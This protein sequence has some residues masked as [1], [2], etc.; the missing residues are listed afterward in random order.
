MIR[1]SS[2]SFKWSSFEQYYPFEKDYNGGPLF[3]KEYA[4]GA[5]PNSSIKN[6]DLGLGDPA[7]AKVFK[8][9]CYAKAP[10]SSNLMHLGS[11]NFGSFDVNFQIFQQYARIQTSQSFAGWDESF[12]RLVYRK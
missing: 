6:V 10:A 5:L 11:A 9:D 1:I 4:M 7:S 3:C 2:D 8:W 12:L